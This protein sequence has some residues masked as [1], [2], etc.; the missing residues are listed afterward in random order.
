MQW[1]AGDAVGVI[2]A[3]G[4]GILAATYLRRREIPFEL[5]EARDGVGGTWHYDP[6]G[7]GSAAYDSLVMNTTKLASSPAAMRIP[8]PPW[9]YARRAEMK[10]YLE[11]LVDREELREHIRLGW[12]VSE[13]TPTAEG[14][15]LR[16]NAGEDRQYR[17]I[18]CAL[19]TNG[20]PR[21][22]PIPGSFSG[23][24]LHSAEYRTPEQFVDRNVLVIGLGTSGA[25]VAG[26]LADRA[27]SVRV[28]V[29]SPLWLMTRRIGGFPIDWIDNE[30]VSRVLP[31]S[32]RR[33]VVQGLCQLTTGR[34]HRLGL[35]RPTR[36]C[37]DDIIGIS[38]TFPRAVRRGAI[39]FTGGVAGSDGGTV[40]FDDGTEAEIDVIV[41][42]TGFTPPTGFLPTLAQPGQYNLYRRILHT[43]VDGLYFVGMFE[44]HRA[45]LPIAEAQARWTA[46]ALSGDVILPS[47][48]DRRAVARTEGERNRHDFGGRRAFFVDWANYKATLTK[49]ARAPSAA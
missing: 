27:R 30:V 12:R 35:P 15:T 18:V 16:S 28:A 47:A 33:R 1:T 49:D 6:D 42:A 24:Q 20:A 4:S 9:H 26:E 32:L 11:R 25:E 13:A 46:A 17:T 2:G 19:G 5:L 21:W 39:S 7:G 34:L 10:R 3:G 22:A 45:L 37:G 48:E 23:E 40:R 36:R 41:H 43:D 31:W 8:G 14:W 29:R 44:A 38:D